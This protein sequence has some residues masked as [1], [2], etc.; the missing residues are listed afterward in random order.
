MRRVL[1]IPKRLLLP[2]MKQF[3]ILFF[4]AIQAVPFSWSQSDTSS[5]VIRTY[6]FPSYGDYE[7]VQDSIARE[8]KLMYLPVAGCVVTDE[9]VDSITRLN[10]VTYHR[11]EMQYGSDWKK[12]FDQQVADACKQFLYK[13]NN[14][15][16]EVTK[17][18]TQAYTFNG[19]ENLSENQLRFSIVPHTPQQTGG[20]HN[21][22]VRLLGLQNTDHTILYRGYPNLIALEFGSFAD[23]GKVSIQCK[24]SIHLSDSCPN[25]STIELAYRPPSFLRSDTLLVETTDGIIHPFIFRIQTLRPPDLYLNESL[26]D[27]TWSISKL[28]P[29]SVLSMH[30]ETGCLTRERYTIHSW[31]ISWSKKEHYS[32]KGAIIPPAVIRK[33]R[34]LNPGTTCC[35]QVT[36]SSSDCVL[37]KKTVCIQL[38]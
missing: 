4:F 11:L 33:L 2:G 18:I 34:K 38:I 27:S 12:R 3:L 26:L 22:D 28:N 8:W 7:Q 5:F 36:V 37:R 23:A 21:L 30:H 31:E 6:G 1:P 16:L 35:I 17:C 13:K 25:A 14:T 24:G 19:F 20:Q 10:N 29:L 9:F 15:F 32:G